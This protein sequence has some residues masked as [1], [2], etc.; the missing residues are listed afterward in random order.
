MS[1]KN[2]LFL[3]NLIYTNSP[4]S[5]FKNWQ[6]ETGWTV[7]SFKNIQRQY[8]I[9][10]DF[11]LLQSLSNIFIKL[12]KKFI[13]TIINSANIFL[14]TS[15][16]GNIILTRVFSND[17]FEIYRKNTCLFL[18]DKIGYHVLLVQFWFLSFYC[19]FFFFQIHFK[20]WLADN[21][22]MICSRTL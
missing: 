15:W 22:F 19:Q 6:I 16:N 18:M 10:Y 17:E 2:Y 11:I 20:H 14:D 9:G 4:L 7:K 21:N 5:Q 8:L 3:Y 12:N 13:K 1:K